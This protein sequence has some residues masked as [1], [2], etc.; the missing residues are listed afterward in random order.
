MKYQA[1]TDLT[2]YQ[3]DNLV[4]TTPTPSP[5]ADGDSNQVA[6]T[7]EAKLC[8]D[9]KTYVGKTGPKCEFAPCP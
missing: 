3:Q 2:K 4:I 1:M 5:T 9:G 8:P 6:C 7:Q